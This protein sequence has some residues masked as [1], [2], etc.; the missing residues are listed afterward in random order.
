MC[1]WRALPIFSFLSSRNT[2]TICHLGNVV[3]HKLLEKTLLVPA[4]ITLTSNATGVPF[5]SVSLSQGEF[6]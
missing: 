4:S 5:G 1:M 2:Y 6:T 3:C